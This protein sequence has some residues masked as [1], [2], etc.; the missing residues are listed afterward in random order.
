MRLLLQVAC[1]HQG[2][3]RSRLRKELQHSMKAPRHVTAL[4]VEI[5]VCRVCSARE[6][7]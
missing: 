7:Q 4:V 5:N 1:E 6:W 2:R 3:V